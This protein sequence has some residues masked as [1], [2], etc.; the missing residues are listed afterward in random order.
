MDDLARQLTAVR[1]FPV[2]SDS[3]IVRFMLASCYAT[4]QII[5]D[6]RELCAEIDTLKVKQKGERFVRMLRPT[7][8]P[9]VFEYPIAGQKEALLD[10]FREV[11]CTR[12]GASYEI[13]LFCR[14]L[15][16]PIE[17]SE[18]WPGIGRYS[19]VE[20]AAHICMQ[21]LVV[22]MYQLGVWTFTGH[23]R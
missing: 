19:T 2:K 18:R 23:S 21:W 8:Y 13:E 17:R 7:G 4:G 10:L 9:I 16:I 14:V 6:A 11:H 1:V 5:V 22:A 15:K 3:P 12:Y 20:Y